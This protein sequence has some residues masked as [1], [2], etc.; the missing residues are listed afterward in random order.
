MAFIQYKNQLK[1]DIRGCIRECK[2]ARKQA[3]KEHDVID[4]D[5]KIYAYEFVL[6]D[7]IDTVKEN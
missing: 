4:L 3:R 2:Q 1:K 6:T 5:G 7:L